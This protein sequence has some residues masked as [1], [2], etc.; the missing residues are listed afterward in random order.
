MDS[1]G[2]RDR[3]K[4]AISGLLH[5]STIIPGRQSIPD[6]GYFMANAAN[7]LPPFFRKFEQ[8]LNSQVNAILRS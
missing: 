6:L 8:S 5:C 2:I 7:L 1:T 4:A 3:N